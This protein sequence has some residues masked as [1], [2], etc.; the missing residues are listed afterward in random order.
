MTEI[1]NVAEQL[2]KVAANIFRRLP[3]EQIA[4]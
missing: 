1:D 3:P 4:S 2:K